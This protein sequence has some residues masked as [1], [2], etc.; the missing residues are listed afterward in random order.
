M[1]KNNMLA[2]QNRNSSLHDLL[3]KMYLVEAE[4]NIEVYK[5]DSDDFVFAYE[6]LALDD[7]GDPVEISKMIINDNIKDIKSNAKVVVFG[8]GSGYLFK[9]LYDSF[10]GKIMLFEPKLDIL[11]YVLEFVDFSKE[12]SD[13]RVV[14]TNKNNEILSE[15]SKNDILV[16]IYPDAYSQLLPEELG[17]FMGDIAEI[18][19]KD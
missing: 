8:L 13:E 17:N 19:N 5:S 11:R 16:L 12:F 18:I 7:M 10:P 9:T 4:E 14:V 2:L 15:I 3:N 1:F 6:G